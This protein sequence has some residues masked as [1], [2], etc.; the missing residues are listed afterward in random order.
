MAS[1]GVPGKRWSRYR[2]SKAMFREGERILKQAEDEQL[3]DAAR[4]LSRSSR[5]SPASGSTNCSSVYTESIPT[6]RSTRFF[7][8][9]HDRLVR[10]NRR[11]EV[12]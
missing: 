10:L 2:S 5:M 6:S 3:L 9:P 8:D 7:G 4:E 12:R 1:S 11:I